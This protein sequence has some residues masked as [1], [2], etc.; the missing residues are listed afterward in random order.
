[1]PYFYKHDDFIY[2]N[3]KF[4][5]GGEDLEKLNNFSKIFNFL[6]L[7]ILIFQIKFT[8]RNTIKVLTIVLPIMSSRRSKLIYEQKMGSTIEEEVKD[9]SAWTS[10]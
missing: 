2:R 8:T 6:L 7:K 9:V 1:M 10:T 3:E 4:K 5:F